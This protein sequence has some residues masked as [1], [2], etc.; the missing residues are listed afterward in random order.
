M[1]GHETGK[2]GLEEVCRVCPRFRR[3]CGIV[4]GQQA[5][6]SS[7]LESPGPELRRLQS[8]PLSVGSIVISGS[9]SKRPDAASLFRSAL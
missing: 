1:R 5:D 8:Q 2:A 6:P 9:S 3:D 4:S 7:E